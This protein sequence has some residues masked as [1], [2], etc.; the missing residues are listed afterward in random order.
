MPSHSEPD[1]FAAG[2]PGLGP[3]HAPGLL[4]QG[5][6]ALRGA[7]R[8]RCEG[9]ERGRGCKVPAAGDWIEFYL[10]MLCNVICNVLLGSFIWSEVSSTDRYT[11]VDHV[12]EVCVTN[13]QRKTV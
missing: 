8:R 9:G 1:M 5:G 4:P 10:E 3:R 2:P 7:A 11:G 12:A 6:G 13:R